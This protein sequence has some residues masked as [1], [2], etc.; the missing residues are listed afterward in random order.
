MPAFEYRI[1]TLAQPDPQRGAA[2]YD[3]DALNAAGLDGW[4]L[5]AINLAGHDHRSFIFKRPLSDQDAAAR[6]KQAGQA[7]VGRP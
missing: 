3:V 5:V 7:R 6:K 4:E 1:I 2:V